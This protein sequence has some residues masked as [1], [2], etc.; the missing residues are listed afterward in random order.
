MVIRRYD[1]C[2]GV[3]AAGISARASALT[4]IEV[5]PI[6]LTTRDQRAGAYPSGDLG[7]LRGFHGIPVTRGNR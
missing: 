6:P 5:D 3:L 2:W 7:A 4:V 1:A